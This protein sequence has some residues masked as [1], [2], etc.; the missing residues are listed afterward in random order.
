MSEQL[1]AFLG[2]TGVGTNSDG[3]DVEINVDTIMRSGRADA[4]PSGAD[5]KVLQDNRPHPNQMDLLRWLV[6]DIAWGAGVAPEIL[7][8]QAG[9]GSAATRYLMAD[10]RRWIENQ[11]R[12]Q[13]RACQRMWTF[14]LAKEIKAGRVPVPKAERWWQCKWVA[15]SDMTIDRGRDGAL[16]LKQLEANMT[17]YQDE[18]GKAGKDWRTQFQK[19][20]EAQDEMERLGITPGDVAKDLAG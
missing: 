17:T 9:L 18:Y 19:I 4:L 11:Q 1:A 12:I 2:H 20:K 3:K 6:R 15:Q 10:T 8:E 7:W 14:T 5:M 13:R 16:V